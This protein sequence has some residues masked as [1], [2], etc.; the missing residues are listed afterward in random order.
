M[1]CSDKTIS[2][3]ARSSLLAQAQ[4]REVLREIRRHRQKLVFDCCF[5]ETTGD[6]DRCT[7]LRSLGKCNFFTKEIDERQLAGDFRISIH[8]AKDLPEAIPQGLKIVA[9]TKGLDPADALV[10][11][12]GDSLERLPANAV[13][14]TSSERRE[15]AVRQ[16]LPHARFIDLRGTIGERLSLL[17]IGKADGVVVAEAALIRL[18][19]HKTLNRIILPGETVPM[20]G[21]LAI[22]CRDDDDEMVEMFSVIDVRAP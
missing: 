13:I 20:Q 7:S 10:M 21:Q 9:I 12:Q 22:L 15:A 18:R 8:S 19:L 17:N 3:G 2:V 6:K 1:R 11:R 5:L 16:L 4:V 14:A